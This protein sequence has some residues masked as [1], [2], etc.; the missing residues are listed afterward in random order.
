LFQPAVEFGKWGHGIDALCPDLQPG[1]RIA[2][3]KVRF[4]VLCVWR[5]P[6]L[7]TTRAKQHFEVLSL[8]FLLDGWG[9]V[10][11]APSCQQIVKSSFQF[12]VKNEEEE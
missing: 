4:R 3:K 12:V 1:C 11:D 10:Q 2:R 8:V 5:F 9:E 7:L 6:P